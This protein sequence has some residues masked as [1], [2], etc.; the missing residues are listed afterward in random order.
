MHWP[1]TPVGRLQAFRPVF[2]PWTECSEHR[3]SA[4]GYRFVRHGHYRTSRR[5]V[6]RFRCASCR[7][8]FSRQSFT[9]SY[10]LKRPELLLPVAAGLVA[11]SAHR[12]LARS[13]G[14]APSTV[15]RLSARLGRHALLLHV[16]ALSHLQGR[17]IEP[18]AADHFET[19]EFS[20]DFPFGVLTLV[21]RDSWFVFGLDPAPHGRGGKV[22]PHQAT[23]LATRPRVPRRGGYRGSF[24]RG[25]DL[26]LPLGPPGACIDVACDGKDPYREALRSHPERDRIHLEVHPN[27]VRGPKGSPRSPEARARDRAMHAVDQWHSLLR[28]TRADHKR[29]TIAFGR[30]LNAILERLFLA[31]V[32]RNFIKG[33]SERR[34][35]PD[36]PA[37]CL[38]LSDRPWT[39]RHVLSRR[40]FP[41][42]AHLSPVL[43]DLYWRDWLSPILPSNRPH[44]LRQAA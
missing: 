27:P 28:H 32:W 10:Y 38:G 42:R 24:R 4:S 5:R 9:T 11:G 8:C 29:E 14:C 3:R 15:T 25:L 34:P 37:M 36:T 6:P 21:G 12:Q 16:L 2:C 44:R 23:R 22:T 17:L 20:Q 13:F 18:L 1:G 31:T 19:F 43:R 41:R 39:W 26:I 33:R 35:D 40:L 7:R 30:R